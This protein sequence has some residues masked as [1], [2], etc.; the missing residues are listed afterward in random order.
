[1]TVRISSIASSTNATGTLKAGAVVTFTMGISQPVTVTGVPVLILNDGG[2][3][4]Y[5]PVLS[6]PNATPSIMYFHY[7]VR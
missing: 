7:T 6:Q 3:A 2:V 4:V 5:D 1:M